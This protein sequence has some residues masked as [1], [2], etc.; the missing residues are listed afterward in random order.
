VL[1]LHHHPLPLADGEGKTVYGVPDE[2]SM[3]LASPATFLDA[4]LSL[5]VKLILHGH[6]HVQGLTRYSV[7]NRRTKSS[8]PEEF[9]KTLYVLS[10]PSST[11]ADCHAGFNIIQFTSRLYS[12]RANYE[13]AVTRY[14]RPNNASPFEPLERTAQGP[15][16]LPLDISV[17]RDIALQIEIELL[18]S[19]PFN[20]H[21]LMELIPRLFIR[22]VFFRP[23]YSWPDAL[24]AYL[25]TYLVWTNGLLPLIRRTAV[26]G[27]DASALPVSHK[28]WTLVELAVK[29][30][31]I[32]NVDN[33]NTVSLMNKKQFLSTISRKPLPS[34]NLGSSEDER[35]ELLRQLDGLLHDLCRSHFGLGQFAP[36]G[37]P[38]EL[39][40]PSMDAKGVEDLGV[41][42]NAKPLAGSHGLSVEQ[43]LSLFV[44]NAVVRVTFE[45]AKR[46]GATVL[47]RVVRADRSR[48]LY[49]EKDHVCLV[50]KEHGAPE[51]ETALLDNETAELLWLP[52][53]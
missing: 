25:V 44:P 24:Y 36:K 11:G 31:G 10:C 21:E 33:F 38:E 45:H 37:M 28:L 27:Q 4:A 16:H 15:I 17:H 41:F 3:Y 42:K 9:W 20:W 18:R 34:V 32:Q 48:R 14:T 1:A 23:E 6:R 2:P 30:L 51:L 49:A 29:V 8:A 7:P 50:F 5:D 13:F 40:D 46:G 52:Q 19:E 47:G 12:G 39:E 26:Q 22:R 35:V 53:A 43:Q